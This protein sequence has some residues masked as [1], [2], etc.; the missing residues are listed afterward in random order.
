[1]L[2]GVAEF[3]DARVKLG[4]GFDIWREGHRWCSEPSPSGEKRFDQRINLE[5]SA[6]VDLGVGVIFEVAVEEGA[7]GGPGG[8]HKY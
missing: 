8:G 4:D 7:R 3:S 2:R 1:M 6:L 5:T